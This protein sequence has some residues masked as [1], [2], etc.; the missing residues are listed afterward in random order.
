M[1]VNRSAIK[2][3]K[4]NER[5][6][7]ANK[8]VKSRV[9]KWIRNIRESVTNNSIDDAKK[10]YGEFQVLIDRAVNKGIYH[11][12]NAARKKARLSK[13]I[14]KIEIVEKS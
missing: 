6:R 2:R 4:Q 1:Q 3:Q 7:M 11:K 10:Y 12:N 8:I 14:K 5:K 13:L 9:K